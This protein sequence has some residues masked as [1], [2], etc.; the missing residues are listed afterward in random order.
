ML[1]SF[2]WTP[3]EIFSLYKSVSASWFAG[4]LSLECRKTLI[5]AVYS[6][7]RISWYWSYFPI[8]PSCD[9]SIL[10]NE[11]TF[12]NGRHIWFGRHFGISAILVFRHFETAAIL[13]LFETVLM[14]TC[15]ANR[16]VF[17]RV[18]SVYRKTVVI[19]INSNR[20]V[21]VLNTMSWMWPFV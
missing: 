8:L 1:E 4:L 6:L 11:L 20:L 9:E 12:H 3:Y 21:I 14:T 16:I 10:L 18:I 7:N 17:Y 13:E 5:L 19:V 15:L 2:F